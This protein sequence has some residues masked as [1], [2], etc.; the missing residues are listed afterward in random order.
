MNRKNSKT[1]GN[2]LQY[3]SIYK[4]YQ[5][6]NAPVRQRSIDNASPTRSPIPEAEYK[7]HTRV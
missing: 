6:A 1:E 5:S 3:I 7:L 4:F 2:K